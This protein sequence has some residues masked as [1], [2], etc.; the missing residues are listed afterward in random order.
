MDTRVVG[1]GALALLVGLGAGWL[2]ADSG[3]EPT[4]AE[5]PPP[6]VQVPGSSTA[7]DPPPEEG[8]GAPAA[9]PTPAGAN[10][11]RIQELQREVADLSAERDRLQRS[12]AEAEQQRD[13]ANA[14]LA[15]AGGAQGPDAKPAVNLQELSDA[16]ALLAGK[17]A[18]GYGSPEFMELARQLEAAGPQGVAMMIEVLGGDGASDARFL[19]AGLLER[20]GDPA[21]LPALGKALANDADLLVR[22]AA[23]HAVGI[24]GT[25][26]A[27][28]PLRTAMTGDDD[29]GVRVNAAY[30]VA[31]Q[32]GEDGLQMLE[33][34]YFSEDTPNEYLLAI[35]GGLADVAAPSTSD[36]FRRILKDT[37]DPPYLMIAMSALAKMKDEGSIEELQRIAG[38]QLPEMVRNAAQRT[39]DQIQAPATP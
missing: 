11:R 28:A 13:Q 17:G 4:P 23:S 9:T 6:A 37:E 32:G 7:A 22:R 27:L 20:L 3:A 5:A 35:L 25:E 31:K 19:A 16:F 18:A 38:S 34:A 30:G 14:K 33:D 1:V 24:I 36:T 10:Q 26:E 15:S 8:S 12:L 21:A 39:I 2:M 29:W